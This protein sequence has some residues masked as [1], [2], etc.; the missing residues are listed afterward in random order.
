[1]LSMSQSMLFRLMKRLQELKTVRQPL[2]VREIYLMEVGINPGFKTDSDISGNLTSRER[3]LQRWEPSAD[4]NVDLALENSPTGAGWDQ[5][6]V[7]ERLYGL[8][9][10]YDENIYTTTIDRSDPAYKAREAAAAKL[11]REIEG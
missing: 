2:R 9:T 7:N 6:E 1:M 11:A 5:F 10:D 3:T 4:T 8:K